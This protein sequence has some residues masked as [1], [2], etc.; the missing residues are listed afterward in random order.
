MNFDDTTYEKIASYLDNQ[1]DEGE[2][3]AFEALLEK[4]TELAAFVATYASLDNVYNEN[5]W[6]VQ[7]KASVD[8]VKALANQFRA[9]DVTALSETIRGIQKQHNSSQKS[10]K[11]YFYIISSAVA[12][13]AMMTLIYFTFMQSLTAIEAFEEYQNW[14]A[15]PSF[16]KKGDTED[17]RATAQALFQ[18]KKY[19][20]A[21]A[22]F[23]AY[24]QKNTAYDPKVQ[25]YI[26]VCYLELENY[27]EAL[28]TFDALQNSKTI[29]NHKAYW[30]TALVY[31]KQND[32]E[33]AK[34]ILGELVKNPTNYNYEKAK[35]LLKKL[36]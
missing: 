30:Y 8:E 16:V 3:V 19:Q 25:L 1:M 21:L 27:H 26:G 4:D 34:K 6:N 29:D 32:G 33:T 5:T 7:S 31:L 17:Q 23:K 18:A 36:E 35:D 10:K 9:D 14:N 24:E 28:Q 20:E 2:K 15:L 22:I 11:S 12:I 13:A